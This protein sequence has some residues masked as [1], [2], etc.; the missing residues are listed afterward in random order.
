MQAKGGGVNAVSAG[1]FNAVRLSASALLAGAALVVPLAVPAQEYPSKPV[2]LMVPFAA[3]GPNDLVM[4]PIAQKL[5]EFLG[6]PFVVDYRAGANGV[7]GSDYVAKAA[8]DGYT[9]L[10]VSS[11]FPV[12]AS[13]SAKLPF[14]PVRDFSGVGA[15]AT[16]NIIFVVN[17]TVPARTVKEFVALA[18]TRPGKLTYASSGTGGSLHLA[19]ELL[20]LTSGI[21]MVHVPYKGAAPAITDLMGGHID[22]MFVAAPVAIPQIK[23]GRVRV[24]AVA[25]PRRALS[26]AETPTFAEAGFPKIEVDSRYGLLAPAATPREVIA[27]LNAAIQKALAMSELRERYESLGLEAGGSTPQEYSAYLRDEIAKWRGVVTAAKLPL[28]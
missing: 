1:F 10:A 14:D 18:R 5:Q 4:R 9:L 21:H 25:S 16:S 28:Q 15:L 24:L 8:P 2:R 27:K 3:G 22:S 19:A 6:Q 20:S 12:N 13:I 26:L 17:P 23:A 11:S 7:I